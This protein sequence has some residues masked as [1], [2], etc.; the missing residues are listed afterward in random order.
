MS[1]PRVGI[2]KS[3]FFGPGGIQTCCI[4][5]CAGLNRLGIVPDVLWDEP[6]DW[7]DVTD[8][9]PD[10]RFIP[11]RL[12]ISSARLR[13]LPRWLRYR[14][15]P[16]SVRFARLGLER[17][18]FVYGFEDGARVAS[19]VPNLCYTGG[20]PFVRTPDQRIDLPRALATSK[21]RKM[22]GRLV[23]PVRPDPRARYVAVSSWIADLF[24]KTYGIRV[25]IVWPPVRARRLETVP[26][27]N[28]F[29]FMSRLEVEKR[30]HVMLSLARRF[31]RLRFTIAG[32]GYADAYV[33]A[34]RFSARHE[35]NG[36]VRL[37]LNPTD[38][39]V[40]RLFAEHEFFV[41]PAQ[42]EHF[43]I[44]TVEAIQAGLIPLVHDSGGQREIV[45]VDA[46]RFASESELVEKVEVLLSKPP[47]DRGEVL[48]ELQKHVARGSP[49]NYCREMISPLCRDLGLTH[50]TGL[51]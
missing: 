13:S 18:D 28:G 16:L 27:R 32:R 9:P 34:L 15:H 48:R 45:P 6:T 39:E 12:P 23:P 50:L 43:G 1:Q 42:W 17:Y 41:F 44:V 19:G 51:A 3:R 47:S 4:E 21:I 40:S 11:G 22:A 14:L 31:P 26:S 24:L 35:A 7:R 30:P 5:L 8:S 33:S 2:V 36:N 25:P 20:P 10:M 29:L 46:L 37:V 49:E 38:R